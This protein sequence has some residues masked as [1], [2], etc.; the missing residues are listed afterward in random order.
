M[1]HSNKLQLAVKMASK[2]NGALNISEAF[3][4]LSASMVLEKDLKAAVGQLN[5]EMRSRMP[6]WS[7]FDL[8]K[9]EHEFGM[10]GE[11]Y[12]LTLTR[13]AEEGVY[14]SAVL[15]V[16]LSE[17]DAHILTVHHL[18][19]ITDKPP[20][21]GKAEIFRGC[22]VGEKGFSVFTRPEGGPEAIWPFL[23]ETVDVMGFNGTYDDVTNR[24]IRCMQVAL[25]H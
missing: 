1:N 20:A 9:M 6:D 19:L 16:I 12:C 5:T 21:V 7:D 13:Q 23:A 14:T 8:F 10:I 15:S 3:R 4:A 11:K 18:S 2:F 17:S 22:R 24:L 25:G